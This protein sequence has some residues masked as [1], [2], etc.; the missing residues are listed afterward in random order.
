MEKNTMLTNM[1]KTLFAQ[2]A[3]ETSREQE[4]RAV[5]AKRFADRPFTMFLQER[6]AR[7]IRREVLVTLKD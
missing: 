3:I 6:L 1:Q 5:H 4:L 7:K 2:L